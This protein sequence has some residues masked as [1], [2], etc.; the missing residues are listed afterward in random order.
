MEDARS[1]IS[2]N[3]ARTWNLNTKK[4]QTYENGQKTLTFHKN[5]HS[6]KVEYVRN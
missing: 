1:R 6:K 5:G 2:K 4:K 3:G